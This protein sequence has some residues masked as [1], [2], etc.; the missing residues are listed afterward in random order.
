MH[1]ETIGLKQN[2]NQVK[3][4]AKK[5]LEQKDINML[6][7]FKMATLKVFKT[8]QQKHAISLLAYHSSYAL[9]LIVRE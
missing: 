7:I 1:S 8:D 4:L 9:S 6:N 5:N 2:L 3:N